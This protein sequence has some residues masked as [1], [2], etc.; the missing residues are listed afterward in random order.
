MKYDKKIQEK[1]KERKERAKTMKHFWLNA[2][3]NHRLFKDFISHD[4]IDVLRYL[5]DVSYN[6]IED[7]NVSNIALCDY[8]Y[9][10]YDD[11]N[12]IL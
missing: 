4:D 5:E 8:Y 11:Y 3:S 6:K 1:L 12:L 2:L 10:L 7:G 9:Y